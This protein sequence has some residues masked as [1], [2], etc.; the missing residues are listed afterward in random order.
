MSLR[1]PPVRTPAFLAANRRNALKSTGPRTSKGKSAIVFN[2]IQ[3]G[4][5]SRRFFETLARAPLA[6]QLD[7]SRIYAAL[8]QAANPEPRQ[9][10]WLLRAAAHIWRIKRARER[11]IR[12]PQFPESVHGKL[13]PLP[14]RWRLVNIPG[15]PGER[16]QVTANV[17]VRR[18]RSAD[19]KRWWLPG[20]ETAPKP[21]HV[22][23]TIYCSD[24]RRWRRVAVSSRRREIAGPRLRGKRATAGLKA[25]MEKVL[26]ELAGIGTP[27]EQAQ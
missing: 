22:G 11:A 21:V 2:S 8:Y 7:F 14:W 6:L 9:L 24:G 13:M 19:G 27:Q 10:R 26:G 16:W 25:L 1:K 20:A 5:R 12:L 15:P 23:V 3:H 17:W 4:L 18:A